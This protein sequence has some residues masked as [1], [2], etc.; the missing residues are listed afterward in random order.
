MDFI[1]LWY[2]LEMCYL[3]L[4]DLG[5]DRKFYRQE[6]ILKILGTL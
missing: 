3:N 6:M 2:Y 5:I 1:D 4:Y